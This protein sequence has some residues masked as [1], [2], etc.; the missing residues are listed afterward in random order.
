MTATSG[1][2]TTDRRGIFIAALAVIGLVATAIGAYLDWLWWHPTQGIVVTLVAIGALLLAGLLLLFRRSLTTR[3]A[4][5][6]L[7]IGLGLLVGQWLGPSREALILGSGS[8][9]LHLEGPLQSDATGPAT[10]QMVASGEELQVSMDPNARLE[11]E[12]LEAQEYPFASASFAFG[13]RWQPDDGKREDGL[14]LS[15][16]MGAAFEPASGPIP[17]LLLDS[18]PSSTLEAGELGTVGTVQFSGL[19]TSQGAVEPILGVD[20]DVFGTLEWSC[21]SAD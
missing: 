17:E 20:G 13:D 4:F 10:C 7:A 19:V 9:T 14:V 3:I 18:A 1:A 12:G 5:V 11:I 6:S 2:A 21:G 16:T 8:M 15:F